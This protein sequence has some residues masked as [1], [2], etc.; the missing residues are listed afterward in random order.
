MIPGLADGG[1]VTSPTL[2]VI[3]E[4]DGPEVV[5]PLTKPKRAKQLAEAS[6]LLDLLGA[7]GSGG[8]STGGGTV[9]NNYITIN[10]VGDARMTAHRVA[11]RLALAGGLL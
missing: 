11:A 1:I 5:I 7:T 9:Q 10:E 2:A 6:G 4:G 8:K 3:G